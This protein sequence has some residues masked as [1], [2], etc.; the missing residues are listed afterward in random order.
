MPSLRDFRR[1]FARHV[2]TGLLAGQA[3]GSSTRTYLA[4]PL[5]RSSLS[6]GDDLLE[7]YLH[8]PEAVTASDRVRLVAQVDL[9]QGWLFGDFAPGDQWAV[10][11]APG[12][13]YELLSPE[14]H[15]TEQLHDFVNEALRFIQVPAELEVPVVPG[16]RRYPVTDFHPWLTEGQGIYHV[17]SLGGTT[18]RADQNPY[19]Y[20]LRGRTEESAG[21]LYLAIESGL[22]AGGV[23][24]G[25]LS[26]ALT[27]GTTATPNITPNA[28]MPQSAP[29]YLTAD[30]ELLQVTAIVGSTYG[31]ARGVSSTLDVD[32][33]SGT[34]LV[35]PPRLLL[36]GLFP[37]YHLCRPAGGVYGDQ[38]G[39]TLDTDECPV[40]P[41]WVTAGALKEA[42][43]TAPQTMEALAE[44][45]RMENLQ[46]ATLAF[47]R[48]Q[49]RA[50]RR[51]GLHRTFTPYVT[52]RLYAPTV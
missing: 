42:W 21:S 44:R 47:Q 29:F 7:W 27:A 9:D 43:V 31:L 23:T 35:A 19:L 3:D 37:A 1:R 6:V 12:E 38:S 48:W 13:V 11:P 24:V 17:G 20:G 41:Q 10:A 49:E 39:L 46:Q 14:F 18:V 30:T 8:R 5:R 28:S 32:H 34:P 45:G 2:G 22:S 4:D 15:P 40:D 36:Y 25:T 51:L 26:A 52:G 50:G 33:P 16:P